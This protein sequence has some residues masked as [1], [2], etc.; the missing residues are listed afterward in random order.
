MHDVD[1]DK[2]SIVPQGGRWSDHGWSGITHRNMNSIS[3]ATDGQ[4]NVAS[5]STSEID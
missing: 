3:S 1:E 2:V 4:D 5:V